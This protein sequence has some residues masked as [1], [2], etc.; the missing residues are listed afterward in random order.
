MGFVHNQDLVVAVN[1]ERFLRPGR[2][3]RNFLPIENGDAMPIKR[4]LL[5]RRTVA[6]RDQPPRNPLSPNSR[7]HLRKSRKQILEYGLRGTV[8]FGKVEAVPARR[9]WRYHFDTHSWKLCEAM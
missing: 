4:M 2:L 6:Q 9:S 8:E 7:T 1:D 5:Q 3:R